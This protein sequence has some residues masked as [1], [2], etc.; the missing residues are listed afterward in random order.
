MN[1]N[2]YIYFFESKIGVDLNKFL[3]QFKQFFDLSYPR[4]LGFF[5]GNEQK[6]DVEHIQTLAELLKF[7]D[8][9]DELVFLNK[10]EFNNVRDLELID[11]VSD[12]QTQLLQVNTISKWLR[13]SILQNSKNKLRKIVVT[14]N[15]NETIEHLVSSTLLIDGE[16]YW[17][18]VA[19][20][21]NLREID[22]NSTGGNSLQL[23][24]NLTNQSGATQDIIDTVDNNTI[25]GKDL[26]KIIT[27]ENNDLVCL[28]GSE[29]FAQSVEILAN[30]EA[31]QIPEFEQLGRTISV[32]ENTNVFATNSL[33]RELTNVF[34]TDDTIQNF[35]IKNLQKTSEGVILNFCVSSRNDFLQNRTISLA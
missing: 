1:K 21:N 25:L 30:L 13:S 19:L 35:E 14:L 8:K 34:T 24:V 32:G 16:D 10:I 23:F 2:D 27:F 4:F 22:Y 31:G 17:V 18:G 3:T 26:L 12:M 15:Q 6:L 33:L 5:E 29:C 20:N 11:L 28:N 9:F 7:C